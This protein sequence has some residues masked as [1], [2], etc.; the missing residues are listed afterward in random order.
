MT[1][2]SSHFIGVDL[3]GTSLKGGL[4]SLDGT[5]KSE[6][7]K[8]TPVEEGREGILR[9]LFTLIEEL[10]EISVD[11]HVRAIGI[12]S[13]GRIDPVTGTVLY[14]TDNLPGWTGTPLSELVEGRFGLPAFV[15]NDV[16]AA[17]IGE[18]WMGLRDTVFTSSIMF[19]SLGTGVGGAIVH[20]GGII[21]GANGGAGEVGHILL[22]PGGH[23]CN[24]GQNGCLEQYGSG[25][26]L[27]RIARNIEPEWNSHILLK[28][29]T[30][31]EPRAVRAVEGFA[32]DL[33][34]G[35]ISIRNMLDPHKFI[36]GGGLVDS[37]DVWWGYL[38]S[39]LDALSGQQTMLEVA[40]L[41]NRAGLI[42]AAK[43]AL[44]GIARISGSWK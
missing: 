29:C 44:D 39:K 3:G 6:L 14:A 10:L 2:H 43:L 22:V 40:Q 36:I 26:A 7:V 12:G 8:R 18:T 35:I 4:L 33:A 20:K 31:G 41:G 11:D 42:G 38:R 37:H 19:I 25:T 32:A 17:A 23:P 27:N 30:E 15:D 28:Q 9:E 1:E 5:V 16:N 34:A 21:H 24:C 13:A